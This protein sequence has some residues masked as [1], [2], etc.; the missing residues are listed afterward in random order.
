M[1]KTPVPNILPINPPVCPIRAQTTS[2]KK[3]QA[4]TVTREGGRRLRGGGR[5]VQL[6]AWTNTSTRCPLRWVGG[7][8]VAAKGFSKGR[9]PC[10]SSGCPHPPSYMSPVSYG[11][12]SSPAWTRRWPDPRHEAPSGSLSVHWCS[13]LRAGSVFGGNNQLNPECCPLLTRRSPSE[14]QEFHRGPSPHSRGFSPPGAL[15]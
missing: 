6:L 11:T 10:A 3:P 13:E 1:A 14:R 7:T 15:H 5:W 9:S 8:R 4:G 2:C 12:F